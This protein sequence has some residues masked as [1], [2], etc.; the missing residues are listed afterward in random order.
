MPQLVKK[1]RSGWA[2]LAAGALVASLLAVGASPAGAATD[3][4]DHEAKTG[5]C[6]GDALSDQMFTDVSDMHAF[7][8]AINCIA[9][10]GITNGTG[11]GSTYSPNQDVTRA[12]MAVFIAR[13][14]EAAGFDLGDA[15]SAGFTD[16]GDTWAE[17]QDAINRLASKGMISS[18][19]AY[20]PDD[21]IT[22]GEMATFLIGLLAKTA[23]NVTVTSTGAI[24]LGTGGTAAEAD[25]YFA[26]A[27]ASVPAG[28]DA[29]ISA[30]YE[31]GVTKGASAA[32]VQDDT[33]TPLDTNY[34]PFGTV[35]RGEMAAFITRALGHTTVRPTGIS[36][37]VDGS[38]VVVSARDGD[39]QPTAGVVVDV[40]YTDTS[41]VDLAFR[42][43]GSCNEVSS[44]TGFGM[45][46]CEIESSD[47][48]T[49]GDGDATVALPTGHPAVGGTT[50]WAWTGD[51]GDAVNSS[52]DL[53]Q[54]DIPEDA[55]PKAAARV[56]VST[57]FGASKV[58]LGSSVLYTVQ[59]EDSDG[60]A[61][62]VGTDSKS[63]AQ[64]LVTMSTY[65]IVGTARN[66][67]GASTVVTLPLTTDAD[68]KATFP[69]SGLPDPAPGT[70]A[71]KYEVD[72]HIQPR[73]NGNAPAAGTSGSETYYIGAA[74]TATAPGATGLVPVNASTA[75]ADRGGL[76]FSTGPRVSAAADITITIEPAAEYAAADARGA[77][78]RV[79]VSVT[80]LYGD[81]ITGVKVTLTSNAADSSLPTTGTDTPREF[82][83]GR[84]GSYTY[85]YAYSSASAA[86]EVL[87]ADIAD[88]DHDGDGA[89]ADD[90][91]ATPPETAPLNP[92]AV[93]KTV[94]WA[95]DFNATGAALTGAVLK[96]DTETN[97]IFTGSTGTVLVVSYDSNDRFNVDGSASTYAGFERALSVGDTLTWV[98]DTSRTGSRRVNTFSLT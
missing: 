58:H 16:I 41:G 22:R 35:N 56:R 20:R 36:A 5:A 68:G 39:F 29:E 80:D 82:T 40:F 85:G 51:T 57:D 98:F 96:L 34:E 63:P 48:V 46:V 4:A 28:N 25:D 31:L 93:T 14:A 24:L 3:T 94:E 70:K 50:V 44:F 89:A 59:L 65:A 15:M 75:P 67:Q 76:V 11:D 9:Y 32:A 60:K 37:Q 6:V 53:F 84:G 18:G 7:K 87:T 55:A 30:I 71:D 97:T 2:V 74:G 73:Q 23:P 78:N 43:N 17:A 21:A 33:K 19:G 64:F 26:D 27:R 88:W 62:T 12:E 90:T 52:T 42:A 66:P 49:G 38:D 83:V 81:P 91:T 79:T 8:D 69:V 10:Y 86:A 95:Q 47:L 54:L 77:S 92:D 45:H 61:T 13:A 1:R 72:I